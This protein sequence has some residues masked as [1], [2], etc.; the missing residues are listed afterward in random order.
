MALEYK[1]D[2]T[3]QYM[4]Y[5]SEVYSPHITGGF[6]RLYGEAWYTYPPI[7]WCEEHIGPRGDAWEIEKTFTMCFIAFKNESDATWFKLVWG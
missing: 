1:I 6:G 7:I 2:F 4:R 3:K 5:S